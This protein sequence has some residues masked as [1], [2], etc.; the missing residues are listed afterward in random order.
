[1]NDFLEHVERY[2]DELYRYIRRTVWDTGC[3]DDVFA[4]AVLAAWENYHKFRP[5]TNFRAWLY[6]IVTNKCFVANRE[7]S[8]APVPLEEVSQSAF[9]ALAERPG[10][11]DVLNNP[12]GVLESCGEE[13]QRAFRRLSTAQ[14]MCILLRGV[15]QF[16]YQ[17]IAEIL[18][19]PVGTVMTHLAR[20][21]AR[22]REE[23]LEYAVSEGIVRPAPR[24]L[25]RPREGGLGLERTGGAER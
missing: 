23:L 9:A 3:A 20:G 11:V 10:Y 12:E 15:E 17:E 19:I 1:M 16:S 18:E 13:V 24:L 7:T 8:R 2:K 22:L 25:A 6:R 5:G 4:A 21:R 14:R